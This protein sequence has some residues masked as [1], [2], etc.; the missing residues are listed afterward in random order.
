M[1]KADGGKARQKS[2]TSST[3][4]PMFLFTRNLKQFHASQKSAQ[5]LGLAQ[6]PTFIVD[7]HFSAPTS[8]LP[9]QSQQGA[10]VLQREVQK[11]E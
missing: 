4:P 11:L 7:P 3:L 8:L 10:L 2:S 1:R 9:P 6:N 5:Q